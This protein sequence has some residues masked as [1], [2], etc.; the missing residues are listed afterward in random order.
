[1]ENLIKAI[2]GRKMKLFWV[3]FLS[4]I[5][6]Y[7]SP[8]FFENATP[9]SFEQWTTYGFAPWPKLIRRF[10][11]AERTADTA[12]LKSFVNTVLGE[13]FSESGDIIKASFLE[14]R[15]YCSKEKG[16]YC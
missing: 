8:S 1:M 11:K 14:K 9:V 4:S 2:G 10:M 3:C 5:I 12:L 15:K 13:T 16:L 7:V 6:M